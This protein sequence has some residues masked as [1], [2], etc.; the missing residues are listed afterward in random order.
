MA[1]KKQS[2]ILDDNNFYIRNFRLEVYSDWVHD[3]DNNFCSCEEVLNFIHSH[4]LL[5]L[6]IKHDKDTWTDSDFKE[7]SE[8]MLSH[9]YQVGDKKKTHY[10]FVVKFHNP[11]YRFTVARELGIPVRFVQPCNKY[12]KAL[13]YLI[14]LNDIDKEPYN[15]DDT[16]G[17][18]KMDL[19]KLVQGHVSD[20][21]KSEQII[22]IIL[23]KRYWLLVDLVREVN[24]QGLYSTFRQGFSI[25]RDIYEQNN[26]GVYLERY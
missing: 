8:Y 17:T 19:I 15:V 2:I 12:N 18:L 3:D 5:F 4:Y 1:R 26:M 7:K 24:K 14:H 9:G 13:E 25:Y 16:F 23:S 21:Y 6:G 11:R 20:E 10:H 22:D